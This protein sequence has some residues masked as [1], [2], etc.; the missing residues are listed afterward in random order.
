MKIAYLLGSLNPG[1]SET[2]VLDILKNTGNS[3]L[4]IFCIHRK[5]GSLYE[6]FRQTG[7]SLLEVRPKNR[8]DIF[9]LFRLRRI[10][11]NQKT[12]LIHAH[13]MI[14]AF[15]AVIVTFGLGIKVILTLHGH[16]SPGNRLTY[17]FFSFVLKN[18]DASVFVSQSQ[19]NYHLKKFPG[20]D[21]DKCH[22]IYN[23]I[24]FS[25]FDQRS[26]HD[27][28]KEFNIPGE[29]LLI[30]SVGNFTSGR[31]QLT[32]CRFLGL[33]FNEAG[34][35]FRFLFVGSRNER[36]GW[37]YDEC[38]EFCKENKFD[39]RVIFAGLRNDVPEILHQLDAFVYSTVNDTFGI[40]VIEAIQSGIPVFVNDSEVMQEITGNGKLAIL[41]C[42]KNEQDLLQK[43]LLFLNQVS[44]YRTKAM[45]SAGL[46]R[47]KYSIQNH[48]NGLIRLYDVTAVDS[49]S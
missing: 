39:D 1:G 23:G 28:K 47:E 43:F 42:T 37:L 8:F 9:Y 46:V 4:N 24:D 5:K 29:S 49:E 19:F 31:D 22:V 21:V 14:D 38:V 48:I 18:V 6:S 36:E 40:A 25:K 45:N 3:G 30:G 15:V 2:L 11:K 35:N 26:D 44:L 17:Q 13:L 32:I 41:Y 33:L 34:I 12:E 27:I 20:I 16:L 10:L 7:A